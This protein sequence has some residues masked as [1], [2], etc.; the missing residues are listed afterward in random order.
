[1]AKHADF[2]VTAATV[3]PVLYAILIFQTRSLIPADP[4]RRQAYSRVLRLGAIVTVIFPLYAEWVAVDALYSNDDHHASR[5]IAL[6]AVSQLLLELL[7]MMV[8]ALKGEDVLSG[9]SASE[10]DREP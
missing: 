10:P 9:P 6:V 8:A 1:M 2:Y 5:V 3:I 4:N 7:G